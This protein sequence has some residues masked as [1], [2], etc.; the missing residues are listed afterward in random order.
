MVWPD[1][2]KAINVFLVM[3]TQWRWSGGNRVGLD[4]SALPEVWKRTNVP[5]K[6]R[7]DI[8]DALRIMEQAALD[9]LNR[10]KK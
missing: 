9:E 6:D 10:G 5:K 3:L 7:N 2:L 1:N 8:F 4:Y